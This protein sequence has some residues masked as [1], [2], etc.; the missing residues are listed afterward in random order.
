VLVVDIG[1]KLSLI[2]IGLSSGI[3]ITAL[4]TIPFSDDKTQEFNLA[5]FNNFIRQNKIQHKNAI[6]VLPL[7]AFFV[8]RLRLPLL[9]D[10]ELFETIKWELKSEASFDL[11]QAV[12]SYEVLQQT[13]ASDG[14]PA[15]DCICIALPTEKAIKQ[16]QQLHEAGFSCL[17]IAPLALGYAKIINRYLVTDKDTLTGLLYVDDQS[18]RLC[19]NKD[20][21][22]EFY[23]ELPFSINKLRE[24]LKATLYSDKGKIELSS[25]EI[26][27]ILF[28]V[29]I[30][31][32]EILFRDK[33]SSA[34]LI[35]LIRPIFERL[36]EEIR[37]SLLYFSTQ[38]TDKHALAKIFI[39]GKATAI[40]NFDRILSKNISLPVNKIS[41]ADKI[42]RASA[43]QEEA[44]S[45]LAGSIGAVIEY[46]KGINLLPIQFRV[47]KRV[48]LRRKLF[49]YFLLFSFLSIMLFYLFVTIGTKMYE[50]RLAAANFQLKIVSGIQ[51]TKAKVEDLSSFAKEKSALSGHL[52][53]LLKGISISAPKELFLNSSSFNMDTKIMYLIGFVNNSNMQAET[54]LRNFIRDMR[55]IS[56][57]VDANISSLEKAK[58]GEQDILKFSITFK[59]P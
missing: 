25:D 31:E 55:T 7:D 58:L 22:L 9:S 11:A 24:L 2:N 52:V 4:G 26:E 48:K 53:A 17:S 15:L 10:K 40:P 38:F 21:K 29:G 27:E 28:K 46:T 33:I 1:D 5:E 43:I 3:K 41:L 12:I 39:A 59:T 18:C 42:D 50:K 14:V 36:A 35:S 32:Q 44:V 45:E 13:I 6:I 16:I 23:R 19:I 56:S 37:R 49:R 30:P 34:Q 47:D 57:I 20:G 8:K 54:I 51:Q